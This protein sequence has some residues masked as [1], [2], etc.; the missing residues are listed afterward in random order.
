MKDFDVPGDCW[1]CVVTAS[2]CFCEVLFW[3]GYRS[4]KQLRRGSRSFLSRSAPP[5][6]EA[7][8]R[9]GVSRK[10]CIKSIAKA[11]AWVSGHGSTVRR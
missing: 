8:G 10:P 3:W 11:L 6:R 5:R 1:E 4:F 2:S 7:I 9:S